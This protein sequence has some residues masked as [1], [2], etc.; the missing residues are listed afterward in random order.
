MSA[1]SAIDIALWDIKGKTLSVP[2][3]ESS[4]GKTMD[5]VRIY[6]AVKRERDCC[7]EILPKACGSNEARPAELPMRPAVIN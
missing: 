1:I 5:R 2:V 3:Y 6:A 7:L 4:G